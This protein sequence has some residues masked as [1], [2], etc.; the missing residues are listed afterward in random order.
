MINYDNNK[1]QEL[2]NISIL[3]LEGKSPLELFDTR[4]YNFSPEDVSFCI[5]NLIRS[6][7]EELVN[8]NSLTSQELNLGGKEIIRTSYK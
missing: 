2:I 7:K 5:Q 3:L 1:Q 8:S 4:L 6:K